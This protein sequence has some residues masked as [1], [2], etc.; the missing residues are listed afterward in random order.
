[1]SATGSPR[2]TPVELRL[3]LTQLKSQ[4]P[5]YAPFIAAAQAI[6]NEVFGPLGILA[7]GSAGGR[8]T[9]G[10]VSS[11]VSAVKPEVNSKLTPLGVA[12]DFAANPAAGGLTVSWTAAKGA[13]SDSGTHTITGN[14][15]DVSDDWAQSLSIAVNRFSRWVQTLDS[16]KARAI[17]D[18]AA[19]GYERFMTSGTPSGQ[20][21]MA[22]LKHK[23]RIKAVDPAFYVSQIQG[24]G[25][26][27]QVGYQNAVAKYRAVAKWVMDAL[28]AATKATISVAKVL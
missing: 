7:Y 4:K 26:K 28:L 9:A 25:S 24:A 10:D 21:Q 27:Y 16:N 23:L 11:Y 2:I 8:I 1:M 13:S 22:V 14:V 17:L 18:A 6:I 20:Q 15:E 5:A 3:V 19:V 12:F